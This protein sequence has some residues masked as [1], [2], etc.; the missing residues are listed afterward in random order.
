M[1]QKNVLKPKPGFLGLK[2]ISFELL[3]PIVKRYS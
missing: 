1:P 3:K 2:T